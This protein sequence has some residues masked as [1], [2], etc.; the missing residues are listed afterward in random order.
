MEDDS[1]NFAN[2]KYDFR[3]KLLLFASKYKIVQKGIYKSPI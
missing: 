2:Y 3:G 1:F